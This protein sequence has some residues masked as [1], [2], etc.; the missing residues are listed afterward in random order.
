MPGFDGTGPR[1]QGAMTGR[2]MGYCAMPVSD[3]AAARAVA[4]PRVTAR[5][6]AWRSPYMSA[7]YRGLWNAIGRFSWR[8]RRG[9]G[10]GIGRRGGRGR[11]W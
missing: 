7:P 3:V 2:G 10:R 9:F 8:P 6:A 1:G 4:A 11:W 5:Y